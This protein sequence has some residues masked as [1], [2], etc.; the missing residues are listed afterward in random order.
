MKASFK[1]TWILTPIL[2]IFLSLGC[3]SNYKVIDYTSSNETTVNDFST[4]DSLFPMVYSYQNK[5]NETMNEVINS[6][7]I[8]MEIGNPEGLLGNFVADLALIKAQKISK[9][10]V[11]FC[12]LNN[13][14]LRKPIQKGPITRGDIYELMPFE[15]ELVVL[16]LSGEKVKEFTEFVLKKSLQL[17][18]RKAGVPVSGI[19]MVIKDSLISET[20]I[21]LYTLDVKKKYTVVTSD[22]LSAGGDDMSFFLDPISI[23]PLNLKLRD[24]ILEEIIMLGKNNITVKAQFDGRIRIQK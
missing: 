15:N 2:L 20:R 6:A 8:D 14:G 17:D 18:A 23:M 13:G 5:L 24:V 7:E 21:G 1:N 19:R 3:N 4:S 10:T 12:V 22:Y 9:S 16:E 11:D